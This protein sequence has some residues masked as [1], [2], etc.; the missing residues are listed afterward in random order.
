MAAGLATLAELRRPGLYE[1]LDRTAERLRSGLLSAAA[2]AG[3][4]L[5]V[6][7]L[8]S[9]L[10]LFFS[11]RTPR[12]LEEVRATRGDLY[13][14]FFHGMLDRGHYFAPSAFEAAFV[15]AAHGTVTIDATVAAASEVFRGL[16]RKLESERRPAP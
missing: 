4:P 5:S 12:N 7:R 8:G 10:G 11:P 15:G 6:S 9:V 14:A 3:L 2:E 1:A 13:P 16:A